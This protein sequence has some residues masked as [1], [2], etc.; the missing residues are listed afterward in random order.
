MDK[1]FECF[2]DC[3]TSREPI[4]YIL[5]FWHF[6]WL[7]HVSYAVIYIRSIFFLVFIYIFFFQNPNL[8]LGLI[9]KTI[10][11]FVLLFTGYVYIAKNQMRERERDAYFRKLIFH[12]LDL[13]ISCFQSSHYR[14]STFQLVKNKFYIWTEKCI[15]HLFS[16]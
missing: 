5:L 10:T 2:E 4:M 12:V 1:V 15:G 8:I 9:L 11:L 16:V 7:L 3:P 13:F 6:E 14:R